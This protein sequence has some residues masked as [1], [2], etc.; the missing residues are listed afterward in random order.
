MKR[1]AI[2]VLVFVMV[3]G[4]A[5]ADN[6]GFSTAPKDSGS[7]SSDSASASSGAAKGS[8]IS[9]GV[10]AGLIDFDPVWDFLTNVYIMPTLSY[11]GYLSEAVAI[12]AELGFP[13]WLDPEF[14][15]GADLDLSLTFNMGN[16]SVIV[17]NALAIPI[18]PYELDFNHDYHFTYSPM[19]SDIQETQDMLL[20]GI[21]YNLSS[22][23]GTFYF[24]ADFP[25][26]IMP[27]PFD[28]VGMNFSLGLNGNNGFGFWIR[29][30]NSY[31]PGPGLEFFQWLDL[32]ASFN[33]GSFYGELYVG[34]PTYDGGMDKVGVR[35]TPKVE[36]RFAN[37]LKFYLE[38]PMLGIG[39]KKETRY[40]LT[41]GTKMSF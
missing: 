41:I 35:L 14:W 12:N 36:A 18:K 4:F 31:S 15:L 3:A 20:P 34:I 21:K 8:T 39:A 6:I 26:R 32:F 5:I 11:D 22:G 13:F 9:V 7:G 16:L 17:G 28:Y 24:K 19:F 1:I 33:T 10:E 37:G 2:F 30:E 38:V 40:G 27:D 23:I 25:I 29:E